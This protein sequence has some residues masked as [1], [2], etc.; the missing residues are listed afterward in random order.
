MGEDYRFGEAE[1]KQPSSEGG[2]LR[3]DV[4]TVHPEIFVGPFDA[5]ILGRARRDG[6]V[7][8]RVH[9]LRDWTEDR[10]RTTDDY[11]YGGGGGM[12]MKPE[13]VFAAVEELLGMPPM[14]ADK[15][16]VPPHP[17]LMM[18]PQ[19]QRFD[20]AMAARLANRTR[21]IILCGRYEGF[22][23]RIRRHLVTEEISVGDFV[24]TGGEIPAMLVV[25]AVTRLLPG[26]VGHDEATARDSFATG[27]L[28]HPHYT[29][30]AD[31]RGWTVP[32][33]LTSGHHG[34]VESWRRRESL[35][36]TWERRPDLL[37][38][39]ELDEEARAWIREFEAGLASGGDPATREPPPSRGR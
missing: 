21:L 12:V 9:D 16:L 15:P 7:D 26:V 28:E 22:D 34:Q 19:G 14:G 38:R 2:P 36:R 35:R 10:H 23:E 27:L 33:V 3:F 11:A 13:P 1:A 18:S 5:S 6:R 31:F 39:L 8:I 24:L 25:D 30:P 20:H 17:V 32:E 37:A 29:R 4:L